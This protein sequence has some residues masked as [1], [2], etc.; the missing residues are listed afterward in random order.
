MN[1]HLQNFDDGQHPPGEKFLLYVDGEL[2]PNEAARWDI[3]LEACWVCRVRVNKI[4]AIISDI[5]EFETTVWNF[6]SVN[7]SMNWENFDSRLRL[8]SQQAKEKTP[9]KFTSWLTAF[10]QFKWF[11]KLAALTFSTFLI[12]VIFYQFVIITPVSADE[13]L[14]RVKISRQEK[15]ITKQNAVIYQKL[16]I[17]AGAK[18]AILEVWNETQGRRNKKSFHTPATFSNDFEEVLE[19]SGFDRLD[20]LSSES[21]EVWRNSLAE[22]EEKVS[23]ISLPDGNN[24]F[25]LQTTVKQKQVVGEITQATLII[26]ERDWHPVSKKIQIKSADGEDKILEISELEFNVVNRDSLAKDFFNEK[27]SITKSNEVNQESLSNHSRIQETNITPPFEEV[28]TSKNSKQELDIPNAQSVTAETEVE[29]LKLLHQVKAD[30]GEQIIV[31]RANGVLLIRGLVETPQRKTEILDAL[32]EIKDNLSIKIDIRTVS[33]AAA[34]EKKSSKSNNRSIE[35]QSETQSVSE[36]DLIEHFGNIEKAREFASRIV[37]R[38]SVVMKH[39]YALRR[40]NNQF[41]KDELQNLS[42]QSRLEWLNLIRQHAAMVQREISILRVELEKVF[43]G[44]G[45]SGSSL[46]NIKDFSDLPQSV[47]KLY[48]LASASDQT[49]RGAMTV[50]NEAQFS[51]IRSPQ[52]WQSL[53][54]TEALAAKIQTVK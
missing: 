14:E 35:V 8:I 47:E 9:R 7:Q 1:K 25:T 44:V 17:S 54:T 3:H 34:S 48:Q 33:E 29:V 18:I 5:I 50:S 11:S 27:K 12:I 42:L 31:R 52:F 24:V 13:L 46:P 20:P 4:Q 43:G 10:W 45:V 26:R 49:I 53:K 2:T 40:L 15:I 30:L 41:S 36:N 38:S 21:F 28:N 16:K 51:A 32:A 6:Q 23:L 39:I 19:R 37:N 22:K